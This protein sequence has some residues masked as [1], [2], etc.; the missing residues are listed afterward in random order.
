VAL[1]IVAG[2]GGARVAVWDAGAVED[3]LRSCPWVIEDLTARADRLQALAGATMGPL[4]DLDDATRS[5]VLDRLTVQVA[6]G[7]ETIV[8]AG[9]KLPGVAVVCVGFVEL[10]EALGTVRAGELLYP[11]AARKDA[12]SPTVV[13][14]SPSGAILLV[15]D[16]ALA[17]ELSASPALSSV[18]GA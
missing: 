4:H 17:D 8:E 1:R 9:G 15:G 3:T 14:A 10:G 18:L 2:P 16:R 11:L 13:R 6:R 12:P 5:A 7:N